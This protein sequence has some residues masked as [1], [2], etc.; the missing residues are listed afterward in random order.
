MKRTQQKITLTV[1]CAAGMAAA[2]LVPLRAEEAPKPTEETAMIELATFGAGCFWCVEAVFEELDGV[3]DVRSGYAGGALEKPTYKQIC[4]GDTGHAEVVQIT[5]DPEKVSYG[6][7][8]EI[9]WMSHDPTTLNR[10]G[11]DVGTQYR[12]VIFYHDDEQKQIAEA[13]MKEAG[14]DFDRPIVTQIVNAAT[15]YEAESYHQDYYRN[16]PNAPYSRYINQKLKK[17]QK[18]M[19]EKGS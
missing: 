8:L 10:Q 14:R 9:F 11:A 12:S 19:D 17:L 15:F 6:K 4:R 7:L 16:N 1:L 13:S 5:F 3:L 2:T 18:Q